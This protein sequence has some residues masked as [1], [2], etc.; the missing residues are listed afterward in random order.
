[1]RDGFP[2]GVE[3]EQFACEGGLPYQFSLQEERDATSLGHH[4]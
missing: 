2:A 4:A 1:M 3:F